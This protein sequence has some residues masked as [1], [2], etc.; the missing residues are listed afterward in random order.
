[1]SEMGE[2]G[3]NV[4]DASTKRPWNISY[5]AIGILAYCVDMLIIV[6]TSVASDYLYHMYFYDGNNY[7]DIAFGIGIV[8]GA[9]FLL[10][11]KAF[12]LYKFTYLVYPGRYF[13]RIVVAWIT[14]I[15]LVTA[16]LFLF[17]IGLIFSRGAVIAF[18]SSGLVS[19]SLTRLLAARS[20][21]AL[22][23]HDA[24]CGRRVVVIGDE[25]EL[26]QLTAPS[27]LMDF[28]LKECARF[29]LGCSAD[30]EALSNQELAK[31]DYAV[32]V[33]RRH[34]AEELVLAFGWSK[35]EV[36]KNAE[37]RLRVSPLPVRLLPD[38][39]VRS[40]LERRRLSTSGPLP[41]VE[42]QRTP[43]TRPERITKQACDLVLATAAL[44][45]L[46]PL[47][48]LTA[49]AIK[50]DSPGSVIFRQRR[51]GFDGHAFSIYK[52][53][54]M[55]VLE[56]GALIAQARRNDPRVTRVGHILRRSS[57][58]ELPQLFNVIKGDMSLVG[59]RPHAV[60]HDGQY[61]GLISSYAFRHHVKPGITGWAQV[62]GQRGE[63]RRIED[64]ESRVELDLW[65]INNWSLMLDFRILWRTCFEI[66]RHEAY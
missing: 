41:S 61:R 19:L 31:L 62:N 33:A 27:L 25:D 46:S 24:I 8:A 65:Y 40:L 6:A 45:V 63:T 32:T 9:L 22:I 58:D 29:A 30:K 42:L 34:N 66:M 59:P 39:V 17:R 56:D 7:A 4:E 13:S 50:L 38:R 2:V 37:E 1:M 23:A 36:I 28:G 35:A 18:A 5:D 47:M 15:L 49:L 48:A 21:R 12:D 16:V 43:L 64:M 54:T 14:S 57:I 26:A 11:A 52:F 3:N 55:S 44:I 51:T 53:R 60:A 10:Q 20:L